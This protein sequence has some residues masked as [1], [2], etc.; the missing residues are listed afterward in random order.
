MLTERQLRIIAYLSSTNGWI[1]GND[2]AKVT[3]VS[4]RTIQSDIKNINLNIGKYTQILSNSRLGYLLEDPEGIMEQLIMDRNPKRA[5]NPES[6]YGRNKQVLTIL[7]FEKDYISIGAIADRLFL[8]RS[9]VNSILPQLKRVIARN[10]KARQ[11]IA[12]NKGIRITASESVKRFICMKTLD[13]K[14]DYGTLLGIEDFDRFYEYEEYLSGLI[15]ELFQK[16]HFIVTGDAYKDFVK[17][18]A[19]SIF[20]SN[21]GFLVEVP[22]K[23]LK[24]HSLT[25][26]IG[27]RIQTDLGY[28]LTEAERQYLEMRIHEL[29]LIEKQ[30]VKD[31]EIV[32]VLDDFERKVKAETGCAFVIN[33]DLKR[34]M[35]DHIIRMKRRISEGHHNFGKDTRELFLHYPLEVHLLKTC[36]C[37]MLG[38]EVPE[39]ELGY[40]VLYV[41]AAI[42]ECRW[43]P[44]VILVSDTGAGNLYYLKKKLLSYI[45]EKVK[46]I[47]TVPAYLFFQNQKKY[48]T[49]D[50]ILMTTERGLAIQNKKFWMVDVFPVPEQLELIRHKMLILESENQ[51]EK[52]KEMDQ[53][54]FYEEFAGNEEQKNTVL[55]VLLKT[56][57]IDLEEPT[58]S[59]ES[60]GENLLCI[61]AHLQSGQSII[62]GFSMSSPI[63][64]QG[65]QITKVLIASYGGSEDIISF[66]DYYREILQNHI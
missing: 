33:E 7:L 36:L 34:T 2:L 61:A 66:F 10:S 3:G 22:D 41:A 4:K 49:P 48:L 59:I 50:L 43:R 42:D 45:G 9:S 39:A 21:H 31:Q 65:K 46:E 52:R 1:G 35:A 17:Y 20:R 19:I 38:M 62:R 23:V 24:I 63:S 13:E 54:Y 37:P 16:N 6:I 55:D 11:E 29:N 47:Q 60:I 64:Y 18:I 53:L 32:G 27:K 57:G 26:A 8:S 40:L 12:S 28:V 15:A 14:V 51:E 58:V 5:L 56:A 44:R 25:E 30:P